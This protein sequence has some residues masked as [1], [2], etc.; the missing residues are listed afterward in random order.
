VCFTP[1]LLSSSFTGT[2]CSTA[3]TPATVTLEVLSGT[4]VVSTWTPGMTYS[5]RATTTEA[6]I[7]GLLFSVALSADVNTPVSAGLVASAT[8]TTINSCITHN[9]PGSSQSVS[10]TWMP[11]AAL[12][13]TSVN[14]AAITVFS[15]TSCTSCVWGS[16]AVSLTYV[17]P[18]STTGSATTGTGTAGTGA[19]TTGSASSTTV[20]AATTSSATRAA[21]VCTAVAVAVA[22][23]L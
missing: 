17:A 8:Q 21:G 15:R 1:T 16:S 20:T 4:T 9:T 18:V 14:V 5:L 6:M 10:V 7:E 22:L 23:T 12:G 11:T 2:M 13:T 19:M 3:V